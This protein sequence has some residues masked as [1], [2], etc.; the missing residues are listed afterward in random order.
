MIST[1]SSKEAPQPPAGLRAVEVTATAVTLAWLRATAG[2]R[3]VVGYRVFR[4]GAHARPGDGAP[5]WRS[6]GW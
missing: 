3:R 6:R 1:A 2:S 4:D 5:G